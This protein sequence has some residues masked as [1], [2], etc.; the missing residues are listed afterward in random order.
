MKKKEIL[1][2]MGLILSLALIATGIVILCM[3]TSHYSI[4]TADSAEFGADFY[5]YIYE[6]A[7]KAANSSI[8]SAR[9]LSECFDLLKTAFGMGFIFAGLFSGIHFLK[10]DSPFKK[11]EGAAEAAV[12][13]DAPA[14]E[15]AETE[16]PVAEVCEE[17]EAVSEAQ[18]E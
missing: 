4:L 9:I 12:P 2:L 10:E 3:S 8:K 17:A 5:T 13:A 11:K 15:I 7:Q 18:A 16:A 14:E 1:T 6:A